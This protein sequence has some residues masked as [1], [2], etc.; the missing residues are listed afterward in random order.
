MKLSAFQ[1]RLGKRFYVFNALQFDGPCWLFDIGNGKIAFQLPEKVQP[2][3]DIKRYKIIAVKYCNYYFTNTDKGLILKSDLNHEKFAFFHSIPNFFYRRSNAHS[4]RPTRSSFGNV[5]DGSLVVQ[6]CVQHKDLERKSKSPRRRS[7]T[8]GTPIKIETHGT[9]TV[10]LWMNLVRFWPLT[11]HFG[12][13]R[14]S[15]D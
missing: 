11:Y 2:V 9:W 6:S 5:D 7:Q 4:V 1:T 10:Q 13:A 3:E 14:F 12:Q 15:G 8:K